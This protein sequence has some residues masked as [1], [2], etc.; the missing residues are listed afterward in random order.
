M[1]EVVDSRAFQKIGDA[2]PNLELPAIS[3]G[4]RELQSFLDG[5]R[6]G[7][8]VFWSG[9]CSHC[10]RYVPYFNQLE[11]RH[12]E[13]GFAAIAARY[14]ETAE[15]LRQVV[16]ERNLTFPIL[17]SADSSAAAQF[18]AQQT[19]RAYLVD[20]ARKLLYRGAVDNFKGPCD[21]DYQAYLEPAIESFLSGRPIE[22]PETASFGCAIKTVYYTLPKIL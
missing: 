22:R 13:I 18:F 2:V 7:V 15:E 5:K 17:H 9:V 20:P 12:P 19:P 3:G 4:M 11:T 8:F 14:S 10:V 21:P 1:S 16:A 6:G